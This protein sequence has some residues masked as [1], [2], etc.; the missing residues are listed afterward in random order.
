VWAI[1]AGSTKP[2]YIRRIVLFSG[3]DGTAAAT[4]ARH[5]IRRFRTATPSGG[6]TVVAVPKEVASGNSTAADIRQDTAG[7]AL[8]VTSVTFDDPAMTIGS[9][10]RGVSGA[11]CVLNLDT[12]SQPLKID[13]NDGLVIRN[14]I[15]AVVGDSIAGFIEWEE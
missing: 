12:S 7:G 13:V 5:E 1:R 3:F 2:L 4:T 8:T 9:C 11:V 15:V 6:S 14:S 10:P